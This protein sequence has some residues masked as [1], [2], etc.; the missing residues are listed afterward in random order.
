VAHDGNRHSIY[1]HL[2]QLNVKRG[3]PVATGQSVGLP[4]R[5]DQGQSVVYFELRVDG[6]AVDPL[7]WLK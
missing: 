3:Q 2:G 4:G 5:D 1:A 7:P 6:Q